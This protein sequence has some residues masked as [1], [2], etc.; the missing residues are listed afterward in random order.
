ME[1]AAATAEVFST[2]KSVGLAGAVLALC[3]L[4]IAAVFAAYV[5]R[6]AFRTGRSVRIK[7]SP[8]SLEITISSQRRTR[9]TQ[10]KE[11]RNETKAAEVQRTESIAD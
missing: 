4:V 6:E 3:F 7:V 2:L 11:G 8:R 10:P 5:S 9:D 1:T